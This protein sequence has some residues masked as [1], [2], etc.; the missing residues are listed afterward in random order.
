MQVSTIGEV[1]PSPDGAR[2]AWTQSQAIMEPERSE[3]V[4]Q[5]FLADADGSRRIQL[6]RGEKSA[7]S[8]S[9][10]PDG[11]YVYFASARSGKRNVYRIAIAGGEAEK[12]TDFKGDIGLY[13]LSPDGK[14]VAFTGYEPPAD[15][16][17]SKK[18]KRDW[19]VIDANPANHSL[20]V[21]PA[22]AD[23][24]GQRA[25]KKLTDGKRHVTRDRLVA[26]FPRD[27]LHPP[28]HAHCGRLDALRHL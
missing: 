8:P 28:A 15:D 5:I 20:Y 23:A 6:T 27:R 22:E 7:T 12:I 14:D 13:Q 3:I 26:R 24:D 1:V 10:S 9:F 18:E 11:L 17:K 25:A 21:I 4:S 19:R 16:E 2:V